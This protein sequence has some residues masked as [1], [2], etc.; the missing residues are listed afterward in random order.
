MDR[1]SEQ[2]FQQLLSQEAK[3]CVSVYLPTNP[4]GA[5]SQQDTLRLKN[6]LQAAEQQLVQQGHRAADVREW[7]RPGRQLLSDQPFW[8]G[9]SE[10]LAV[11]ISPQKSYFYRLPYRFDE[12]LNVGNRVAVKS[13]LPLLGGQGHFYIL[14]ISQNKVRLLKATRDEFKEL[15]LAIP[16]DMT[17]ALNYDQPQEISQ[18]HSAS[19]GRGKQAAVFHGQ[20]GGP[21]A[22]KEELQQYCRMIDTAVQ[23]AVRD[24]PGPLVLAG[25]EYVLSIYRNGSSYDRLVADSLQGNTDRLTP[26]ELHAQAWPIAQVALQEPRA[27]AMR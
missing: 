10:G 6:L 27:E 19:A 16:Q 5:D 22:S 21:D 23:A 12:S 14:A 3:P 1:L 11:F 7:L 8:A 25:V 18:A 2:E 15:D 17:S 24:Q 20:G 9:R 26:H 13:L 4:A